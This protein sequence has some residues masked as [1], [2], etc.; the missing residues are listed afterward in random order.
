MKALIDKNK[1]YILT[2][3][4]TFVI[5]ISVLLIPMTPV[6]A[7]IGGNIYPINQ[8]ILPHTEGESFYLVAVRTVNLNKL[9]D[10]VG[11]YLRSNFH[12]HFEKIDTA[13]ADNVRNYEISSAERERANVVFNAYK[14]LNKP[15]QYSQA[16]KIQYVNNEDKFKVGDQVLKIDDHSVLNEGDFY[17]YLID[18]QEQV[19]TI[20]VSRDGKIYTL[21]LDL[22]NDYIIIRD[23]I[24]FKDL[25][26]ADLIQLEDMQ[27]DSA[28]LMMTLQLIQN[29][30]KEDLIKGYKISGT[31]TIEPDGVV[32]QI[33]AIEDKVKI[34]DKNKVDIFFVPTDNDPAQTNEKLAIRTA[35]E[36]DTN[37][38]IVPVDKL[39]DAIMYLKQLSHKEE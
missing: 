24:N 39:E 9:G 5:T 16:T 7:Y 22:E 37:M 26:P 31:G 10:Y 2:M 11:V 30:S 36:L 3:I 29:S 38:K 20:T 35:K 1:Y 21:P 18:N 6:E 25:R 32:G 33:G 15:F 23:E 13:I 28:G 8:F 17:R 34:A 4:L 14:Y 12:V 19:R 27:G